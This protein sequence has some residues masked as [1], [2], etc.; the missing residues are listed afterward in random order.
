ML[1]EKRKIN[2]R[3]FISIGLLIL[4]ILAVLLLSR[5]ENYVRQM[6]HVEQFMVEL[7]DRTT[8]HVS[9]IFQDKL[10]AM[11]ETAYLYG[12]T[13]DEDV[14]S[15]VDLEQ[16][17]ALETNSGFD[18]I[19]FVDTNG[20][21]YASDGRAVD[22]SDRDYFT[23]GIK[24]KNGISWV[25]ESRV[26]GEKLMGFYAPIVSDGKVQG[27]LVGFLQ[28]KTITKILKT[29]LYGYTAN[30]MILDK[31]ANVLG[32]NLD[33]NTEDV[34]NVTSLLE[35]VQKEKR[36]QVKKSFQQGENIRF[37]Y[38]GMA[39][40]SV[41]CLNPIEGTDWMLLQLFPSEALREVS[42]EVT[43]DEQFVLLLLAL[44]CVIFGIQVTLSLRKRK[45][46]ENQDREKNHFT[47]LLQS[48][49]DDYICLIDVDL[50]TEKEQQF[51][52][53]EGEQLEDWAGG[54]YDYN[55][56]IKSY[57]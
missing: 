26:S 25:P 55:H 11:V 5:R 35:Y 10:D 43:R 47:S 32:R 31:K 23:E 13:L 12:Q 19:R 27:V 36:A 9:D 7:S 14:D 37:S 34:D 54:N 21:D 51:R 20:I 29:N 52:M 4:G 45:E 48:M 42:D 15:Q 24:G 39:G 30:T 40:A 22:V 1:E 6:R 33:E 38:Q 53:F 17:K 49:S 41:A 3:M 16:L 50:K 56:C 2:A 44:I 8:Q 46:I 28:E 57:P 18:W